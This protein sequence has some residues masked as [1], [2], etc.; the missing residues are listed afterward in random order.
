M[1]SGKMSSDTV[2]RHRR[3]ISSTDTTLFAL[4]FI[5]GVV[6]TVPCRVPENFH[7]IRYSTPR[8]AHATNVFMAMLKKMDQT[9]GK[10]P[11]SLRILYCNRSG[12]VELVG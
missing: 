9:P 1:E 6:L 10:S 7:R 11:P 2:E 8:D 12:V 3:Q 5:G 4:P